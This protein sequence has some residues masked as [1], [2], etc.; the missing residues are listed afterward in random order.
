MR[1]MRGTF[2]VTTLLVLGLLL[3]ACGN[4]APNDETDAPAESGGPSGQLDIVGSDT[5]V[6]LGAALAEAYMD[7]HADVDLIVQGG[8]SGTG[9]AAML[10]ENADIAQMSRAMSDDEWDEAESLGI[11]VTEI[12]IAFDAIVVAVHPENPVNTLT[13]EELGAIYRG[14]ITNWSEVGGADAGIVLL[15]RDTTSGTHVFFREA[16]VREDGA[17]PDAEFDANAQ[18]LPSTQA[19]AD[20][21]AQNPNAIGYIGLGYYDADRLQVVGFKLDESDTPVSPIEDHPDGLAYPLSRPLYFYV[22][23]E[24]TGLVK[25]YVDF[26][27]SADGQ[28]VVREM[29]FLRLP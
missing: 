9:L 24:Y 22:A 16:I 10:N 27:L 7:L 15:S 29:D 18:F 11:E 6:N 17:K 19:I 28:A 21:T 8:G 4:N 2:L 23:G 12:E 20:E 5:M 25:E 3:V 1:R 26:V 13:L 14:D